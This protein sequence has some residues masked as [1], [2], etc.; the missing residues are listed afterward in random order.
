VAAA[1]LSILWSYAI[2]ARLA[3]PDGV[4][5]ELAEP[6]ERLTPGLGGYVVLIVVGLFFPIVAVIEY[7]LIAL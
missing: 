5:A 7:F 4:D 2:R 6:T 3:H 1:L